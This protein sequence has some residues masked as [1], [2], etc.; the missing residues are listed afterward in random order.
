MGVCVLA[1]LVM[2][3][4]QIGAQMVMQVLQVALASMARH[5]LMLHGLPLVLTFALSIALNLFSFWLFVGA[6]MFFLKIARGQEAT[7]GEMFQGGRYFVTALLA[8]LLMM[9]IVAGGGLLCVIPGVIFWL[10]L[11]LYIYFIVDRNATVTE[12]LS[13]SRQFTTG[14]KLTLLLFYFALFGINFA[15]LL[16]CGVGL[17]LAIPFSHLAMA[18]AYLAMTGQLPARAN[19]AYRPAA[20]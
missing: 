10:M 8:A 16:A 15:G 9:V 1:I 17:L 19:Y 11:C 4:A 13:L 5:H 3:G 18:T 14:N 20:E 12:S 2:F 6:S 7:L